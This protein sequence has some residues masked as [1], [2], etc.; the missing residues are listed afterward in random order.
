MGYELVKIGFAKNERVFSALNRLGFSMKKAQNLCDKGRILDSNDGI[1][2]KNQLFSGELFMIDYICYPK[3]LKPVFETDDFAVFEKPSG[4]CSHPNGRNSPY[5]MYDEIWHLYGREAC[6]AH[7]LD[8]ETSGLLLVAKSKNSAKELKALFEERKVL[9]SYLAL[10]RGDLRS[11]RIRQ[12]CAENFD[13]FFGKL[14][15]LSDFNGFVID[16]SMS[17]GPLAGHTKQKMKINPKGKRAV[18]LL[19]ILEL[20]ENSTLVECY[21]L[22]GR[23]HQIRLHLHSVG[24]TI[25]GDPLYNLEKSDIERILDKKMSE[26]ERVAKTGAKRLMLHAKGLVFDFRGQHYEIFSAKEF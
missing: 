25:L 19:R 24:H 14:E 7:R 18:T 26:P 12:F 2:T 23:Q 1:L 16:K 10:V 8:A 3:G 22:T 15:L 9:K 5:N 4:I 13:E 20:L 21:P 17:L 6:V 11:A